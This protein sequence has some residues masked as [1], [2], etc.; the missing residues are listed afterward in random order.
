MIGSCDGDNDD[1]NNDDDDDD[2][3]K[4]KK[5]GIA[6]LCHRLPNK[7]YKFDFEIELE[8]LSFLRRPGRP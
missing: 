6:A 5:G 7:V 3:N 2:E 8:K 4:K 1:D